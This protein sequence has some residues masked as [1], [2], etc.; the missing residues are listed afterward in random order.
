[1]SARHTKNFHKS[2]L[3]KTS[4]ERMCLGFLLT[5]TNTVLRRNLLESKGLLIYH[6]YSTTKIKISASVSVSWQKYCLENYRGET[7][8]SLLVAR[9]FLLVYLYLSTTLKN[10]KER[11]IYFYPMKFILRKL[12]CKT[13]T[14]LSKLIK[15]FFANDTDNDTDSKFKNHNTG[16]D[17]LEYECQIHRWNPRS[18]QYI[19]RRKSQCRSAIFMICMGRGIKG[20]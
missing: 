20:K 7:F 18:N 15:P 8:C 19:E 14:F 16:G 4:R 13:T 5:F 12:W 10:S 2:A 11:K 1:M 17:Y 9:Y 3:S 6:N